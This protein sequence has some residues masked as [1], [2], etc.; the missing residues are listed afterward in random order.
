M[1]PLFTVEHC[2]EGNNDTIKAIY[3]RVDYKRED[4][5]IVQTLIPNYDN[6]SNCLT[7]TEL[8]PAW[9]LKCYQF[10]QRD[11]SL[12][13][14]VSLEITVP[15]NESISRHIFEIELSF[16]FWMRTSNCFV[17]RPKYACE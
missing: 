4:N 10:R 12:C 5:S 7:T 16:D 3:F 9:R 1:G 13:M 15:V 2:V 6:Y 17:I 14:T 8:K 11:Q